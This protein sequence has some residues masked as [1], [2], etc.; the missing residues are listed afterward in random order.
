MSK[1]SLLINKNTQARSV[2]VNK[3]GQ[4]VTEVDSPTEYLDLR[5]KALASVQRKAKDSVYESF[6]LTKVRGAVSGK[7]YWE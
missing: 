6:G 3:T 2:R 4:V 5:K 1:Y 7:V